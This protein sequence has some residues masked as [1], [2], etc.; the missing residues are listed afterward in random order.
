MRRGAQFRLA[1]IP[2]WPTAER[3]HS[4]ARTTRVPAES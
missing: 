3:T 2:T 1:P 4:P